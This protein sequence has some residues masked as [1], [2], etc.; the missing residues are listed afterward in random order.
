ML[1]L[2]GIFGT[3]RFF[4]NRNVKFAFILVLIPAVAFPLAV[5]A[6]LLSFFGFLD[7]Q[8]A[9]L[10]VPSTHNS[11]TIPLQEVFLSIS[12]L[13]KKAKGGGD[14]TI[15]KSALVSD[16]GPLGTQADN[17]EDISYSDAVSLYT[18]KKGD[19]ISGIANMFNVTIGT[20]RLANNLSIGSSVHEEDTLLILPI[21]GMQYTIKKGDTLLKIAKNTGGDI[22]EIGK[23]NGLEADSK[24]IIGEV[25]VIPDAEPSTVVPTKIITK[26]KKGLPKVAYGVTA[27]KSGTANGPDYGSYYVCPVSAVQTQ[28]LHGWN[29]KDYG[30]PNGTPVYSSAD[31]VIIVARG[32]GWN[33]GYGDN[34]MIK[35]NN[36]TTTVYA[37]LSKVLV[38]VGQIVSKGEIIGRV[39]NTGRSTGPHLHFEVRGASN[40]ACGK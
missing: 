12:D 38:T 31:G 19:T 27:L 32:S 8:A 6:S 39:G 22:D 18:V 9:S 13:N 40:N 21:T 30:A 20:I 25:I 4:S 23:F 14:I 33:S 28:G 17:T 10:Q 16:G 5:Q 24:L 29:G 11:Q 34:I 36:G 37:H 35:H 1:Y 3:Y 2:K 7:A 15:E 26:T